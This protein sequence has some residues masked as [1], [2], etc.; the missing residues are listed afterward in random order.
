MFCS[1]ESTNSLIIQQNE[2]STQKNSFYLQDK[3]LLDL[4]PNFFRCEGM[5][6]LSVLVYV[7]GG[8]SDADCTCRCSGC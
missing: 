7:L 2:K 6:L 1:K 3:L 5:Q 8:A 4:L